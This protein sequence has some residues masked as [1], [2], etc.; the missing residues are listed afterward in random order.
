MDADNNYAGTVSVLG[1]GH[2][3]GSCGTNITGPCTFFWNVTDRNT[4]VRLRP[5]LLLTRM[6]GNNTYKSM[7]Q[8]DPSTIEITTG[9][10]G[11]SCS[12]TSVYTVKIIGTSGWITGKDVETTCTPDG[13]TLKY[14]T[15]TIDSVVSH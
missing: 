14:S 2:K 10:S 3:S 4:D 11:E 15:T 13:K 7:K 1:Q 5:H 12:E 9:R 8:L 6:F